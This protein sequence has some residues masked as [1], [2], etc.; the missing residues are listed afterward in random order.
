LEVYQNHNRLKIKN[1][2][3]IIKFQKCQNELLQ[4]TSENLYSDNMQIKKFDYEQEDFITTKE[5]MK[6]K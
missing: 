1:K 2:Y 4:D 3:L 6:D 5:Q